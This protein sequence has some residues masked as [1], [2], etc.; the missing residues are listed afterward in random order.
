MVS[1]AS[2]YPKT[3]ATSAPRPPPNLSSLQP[4]N[5]HSSPKTSKGLQFSSLLNHAR[6]PFVIMLFSIVLGFTPN[7]HSNLYAI[8]VPAMVASQNVAKSKKAD[9]SNDHE[10]SVYTKELLE[11][12]PILEERIKEVKEGKGEMSVVK[13]ALKTI[14]EKRKRIEKVILGNLGKETEQLVIE[15]VQYLSKAEAILEVAFQLREELSKLMRREKARSGTSKGEVVVKE[16]ERIDELEGRLEELER[17]F[18]GL[19]E[20]VQELDQRIEMRE[21]FTIS[22]GI[23]E[24]MFVERECEELVGELNK[25]L[26]QKE[27][28][29][30]S[31]T[32]YQTGQIWYHYE[33]LCAWQACIAKTLV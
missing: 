12:V 20:N 9:A 16:K 32:S 3:K 2:L 5:S 14:R 31:A 23:R 8:A 17:E 25:W 21:R 7:P 28:E 22:V 26:E 11:S 30:Y 6:Q 15:K 24:I 27:I 4:F 13:E 18:N 33:S 29:R 10:F 19:A 1:T